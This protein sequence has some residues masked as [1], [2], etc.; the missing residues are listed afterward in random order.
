MLRPLTPFAVAALIAAAPWPASAALTSLSVFPSRMEL[1][2]APGERQTFGV[3]VANPGKQPL[4]VRAYVADWTTTLTGDMEFLPAGK[5]SHSAA[6]MLRMT[7]SQFVVPPGQSQTVR[8]T[9]EVGAGLA[10]GQRHG[11]VF[12]ET[13]PP[14]TPRKTQGTQVLISQRLGCTVYV[15]VGAIR[16]KATVS[17]LAYF[18]PKAKEPARIGVALEN[19]GNAYVRGSGELTISRADTGEVI[20]KK[21]ISELF[22][23]RESRR[24]YFT[25][26]AKPLGAGK[27]RLQL[28]LDYGGDEVIEA[29]SIVER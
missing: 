28:R 10:D 3:T 5:A 13:T 19:Q 18:P 12:F 27:Y 2:A 26:V 6:S 25:P 7:P 8:I 15:D 4:R 9:A 20:E 17:G 22:A 29:E 21:P 24:I 23:L 16:R 14:Q 1:P 11:I